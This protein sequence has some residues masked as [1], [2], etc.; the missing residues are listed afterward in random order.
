VRFFVGRRAFALV[1]TL[2]FISLLLVM[3]GAL[4]IVTRDKLFLSRTYNDQTAALYL[5][6]LAI[7]DA[8]TELEADPTWTAG[9]T[10]KVFP[11]TKGSYSLKFHVG[12]APFTAADSVNNFDGLQGETYHGPETLRSGHCLLISTATVGRATRTVEALVDIGGGLPPLDV[13]LLNDGKIVLRGDAT[14]EGVKSLRD[15]SP[16]VAG[17]HSN[18]STGGTALVDLTGSTAGTSVTGLIS[19][20]GTSPSAVDLGAYGASHTGGSAAN[21][22][23]KVFPNVDII[24]QVSAKSSSPAPVVTPV[25]VTVL[26]RGTGADF[27]HNGPLSLNGD[28]KLEGVNL[29]VD[30][31]LTVNGSVEGHGSIFVTGKSSF[32]GTTSV[33]TAIPDKIALYSHGSVEI[34]GF[35]GTAYLDAI[36]AADPQFQTRLNNFRFHLAQLSTLL[37]DPNATWGQ[38]GDLDNERIALA[39]GKASGVLAYGPNSNLAR[40]LA[41]L[42]KQESPTRARDA[43]SKKFSYITE[44]LTGVL[45]NSPEATQSLDLAESDRMGNYSFDNIIDFEKRHL[46]QDLHGLISALNFDQPGEAFFQG[47]VYTHGYIHASEEVTIVGAMAAMQSPS[48]PAVPSEVVG[49]DTLNPGDVYLLDG[50]RLL[51]V[52]DFFKSKQAFAGPGGEGSRMVL[53]MGR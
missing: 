2:L 48:G 38:N 29:Y 10:N 42:I 52:E 19:S 43:L 3:L 7:Q 26:T 28:L 8:R 53:W 23:P 12:S 34:K 46:A 6:E 11:G 44:I 49:G 51:F 13:P 5:A 18:L 24:G 21:A 20:S 1:T 39:R 40:D 27:F 31:P 37:N 4:I 14:I 17:I 50:S 32:Y 22:A 16:V 15:N 36:A 35:D 33:T 45:R 25:G 41:Y 30:G 47:L 9:Y